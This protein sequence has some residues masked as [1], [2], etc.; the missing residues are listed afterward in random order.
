MF[1]NFLIFLDSENIILVKKLK[2]NFVLKL[3]GKTFFIET[4]MMVKQAL[5][6]FLN[7]FFINQNFVT[8]CD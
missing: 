1:G 8:K 6:L 5:L 7:Q 2:E 4:V 3:K